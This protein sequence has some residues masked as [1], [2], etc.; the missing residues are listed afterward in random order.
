MKL[1]SK[2]IKQC[3]IFF[4][5]IFSLV[6]DIESSL[7]SL[8]DVTSG[9]DRQS[10][11]FTPMLTNVVFFANI[12]QLSLSFCQIILTIRLYIRIEPPSRKSSTSRKKSHPLPKFS[13]SRHSCITSNG[14]SAIC[15]M[16]LLQMHFS[17]QRRCTLRET[18]RFCSRRNSFSHEY[19]SKIHSQKRYIFSYKENLKT[20]DRQ[21]SKKILFIFSL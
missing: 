15:S 11:F 7:H 4:Q 20:K 3:L 6:F 21:T 5:L 18:S 16:F 10:N 12:S 1:T 17:R 9:G 13:Y 8:T 2:S 14:A 19:T